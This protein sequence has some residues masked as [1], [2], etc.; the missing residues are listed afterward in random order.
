[1]ATFQFETT[2]QG[3]ASALETLEIKNPSGSGKKIALLQMV[4]LAEA[5]FQPWA[6]RRYDGHA[7]HGADA[8]APASVD[9][10][11]RDSASA[12]ASFEVYSSSDAGSFDW[13]G[14]TLQWQHSQTLDASDAGDDAMVNFTM[15]FSETH[16]PML[17]PG[18]SAS[19][20]IPAAE[21]PYTIVFVVSEEAV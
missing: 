21:I 17:R 18:E 12:S 10:W 15:Y 3:G 13:S 20:L 16:A 8:L 11:K 4:V 1:M 19:V 14:L 2:I 5:T 7:T 6:I 9:I